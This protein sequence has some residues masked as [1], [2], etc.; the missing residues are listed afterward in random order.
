LEVR[1]DPLTSQVEALEV[2]RSF[3][4]NKPN[5]SSVKDSEKR[6]RLSVE[7]IS[8]GTFRGHLDDDGFGS[9]PHTPTEL[10]VSN[11]GAC[12]PQKL[13]FL[14]Y[15]KA[16]GLEGKGCPKDIFRILCYGKVNRT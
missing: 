8:A 7:I 11:P 9:L 16:I 2:T 13:N 6:R 3:A 12:V 5:E 15:N 14:K 10:S 1:I 4:S